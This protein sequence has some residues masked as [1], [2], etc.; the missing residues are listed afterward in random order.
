MHSRL[1]YSKLRELFLMDNSGE[2]SLGEAVDNLARLRLIEPGPIYL[3]KEELLEKGSFTN[4]DPT[5]YVN[6]FARAEI[7]LGLQRIELGIAAT[8]GSISL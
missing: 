8:L 6:N 4:E 7:C 3:K 1:D 5:Y 2:D